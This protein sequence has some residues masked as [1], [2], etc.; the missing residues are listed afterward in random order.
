MLQSLRDKAQGWI[1]WIIIGLIGITFVLFG[2]ESLFQSNSSQTVAKVQG[3]T[4][5][6]RQL[7]LAYKRY[8]NQPGSEPLALL[9]PSSIKKEIL[10]SMIDEAVL[11]QGATKMGLAVS[12]S[13]VSL[14]LESIPV[15]LSDG[16]FSPERYSR[17]LVSSGYTDESFHLYI[18]DAL[19]RHQLQLGLMQSAF[20]LSSDADLLVKYIM[21]KRDLRYL[22]IERA[23][24]EN[25]MTLSE[26]EEKQFYQS[27]LKEFMS[28][29]QIALAYVVL[30]QNDLIAQY[31][32]TDDEIRAYYHENESLFNEPERA[33]VSQIFIALPKDADNKAVGLAEQRMQEIRQKLQQGESFNSLVQAYSEDPQSKKNDGELDWFSP[34]EMIAEFDTA[35]FALKPGEISPPVRTEFGLHLIKLLEKKEAKISSFGNVKDKV[36]AKM[37]Q[38]WA[39]EQLASKA[40][41]LGELAYDHPDSLQPI[42]D[43][44]GLKIQK[45]DLF[46]KSAGVQE[47]FLQNPIVLASA[48]SAT[49]KDDKNNSE[50]LKL[51]NENYVVLRVSDHIPAK[52]LTFDEVK[53]N[54][55]ARLKVEKSSALAAK[56]AKE[57]YET[58]NKN[59]KDVST[60]QADYAWREVKDVTRSGNQLNAELLDAIFSMPSPKESIG[61]FKLVTLDN[62]DSSII[63]LTKVE[64]GNYSELSAEAKANYTAQLSKHYG[65]LEYSL[66]ATDLLK[67]AKVKKYLDKI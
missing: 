1:A 50:A 47:S 58:I 26:E 9:E 11:I 44:L 5:T 66:Y 14:T 43:K 49:V 41:Q 34:G 19:I 4:I 55:I 63:W 56:K 10:Q 36:L 7:D 32:P 2:T 59:I 31:Q 29:E 27:H 64:D 35:A 16:R 39:Q 20:A 21:Q 42:V 51:D 62:G 38:E 37:K 3:T 61:D 57:I 67:K 53:E 65:E 46:T 23:S 54:I 40:E 18:R 48:F 17:F 6:Q 25:D 52:Q 28:P 15:F 8:L 30:S 12:P 13:Q 22:T 45:T 24:L 60:I 33:R